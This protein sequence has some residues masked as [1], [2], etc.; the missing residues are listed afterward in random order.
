MVDSLKYGTPVNMTHKLSE[1]LILIHQDVSN[2]AEADQ[3]AFGRKRDVPSVKLLRALH[4]RMF[5]NV[6]RWAIAQLETNSSLAAPARS[7]STYFTKS[8][9]AKN[10][11]RP[12]FVT[13]GPR[14]L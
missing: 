3:W 11:R 9:R 13:F 8:S 14:P 10:V 1:H 5:D 4:K 12:I 2:I 6:W 7:L